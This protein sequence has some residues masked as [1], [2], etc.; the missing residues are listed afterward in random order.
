MESE[1][2][3]VSVSL[4]VSLAA[5]G[6][7]RAAVMQW[8]FMVCPAGSM[9]CLRQIP[10]IAVPSQ[11]PLLRPSTM[12]AQS[13]GSLP[14][15][16]EIAGSWVVGEEA[17][18]NPSQHV[19]LRRGSLHLHWETC[20]ECPQR[21]DP[22]RTAAVRLRCARSGRLSKQSKRSGEATAIDRLERRQIALIAQMD[23]SVTTGF[24][25]L[26][27]PNRWQTRTA[28]TGPCR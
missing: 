6:F 2:R 23:V 9:A 28:A 24:P 13:F 8:M 27:L 10:A 11:S 15:A 21:L 5:T 7:Q 19:A 17:A 3:F 4:R 25:A 20:T 22:L 18:A 1:K 16:A 26:L 14:Q 12:Q